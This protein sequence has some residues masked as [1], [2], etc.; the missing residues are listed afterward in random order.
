MKVENRVKKYSD[1]QNVINLGE[2]VKSQT[3]TL[4]FLKNNLDHSR[5][6]ISVSKK[7]GNAVIR[8]KIKRQIRA[9]ISKEMDLSK[10]LDL[11]FIA[12]KGF[13]IN[14][15]EKTREDIKQLLEKVGQTSEEDS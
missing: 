10:P 6:G 14:N 12:R 3:L 2:P 9:I 1:F 8:N 13:D 15:F 7:S 4:Y 5:I 11:V